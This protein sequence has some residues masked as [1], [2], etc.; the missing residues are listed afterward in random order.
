VNLG[1]APPVASGAAWSVGDALPVL[2]WRVTQP[3]IDAYARASGDFNPI[4]VDPDYARSGPF[5]RTIAHGLMTLAFV[6]QM[7][8]RWS[9]GGFDEAGEIEVTFISPV[10]AGETVE[11]SGLIE[12]IVERDGATAARVKLICKAGDREILAG[13]AVQPIP[14]RKA[15]HGA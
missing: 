6:A 7:L 2:T 3:M 1:F 14:N 4:H 13:A 15:S 12:A 11:V 9:D 5:G 10:F 8:N